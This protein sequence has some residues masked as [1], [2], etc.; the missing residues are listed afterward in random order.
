MRKEQEILGSGRKET[1]NLGL[2]VLAELNW[3]RSCC[4]PGCYCHVQR[5]T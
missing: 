3:E 2:L 4:L 5:P 1:Q